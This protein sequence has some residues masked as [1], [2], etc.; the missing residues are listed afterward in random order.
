MLASDA[1]QQAEQE[2]AEFRRRRARS[3]CNSPQRTDR[4]RVNAVHRKSTGKAVSSK[5]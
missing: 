2:N 4:R 3:S 1:I 5:G